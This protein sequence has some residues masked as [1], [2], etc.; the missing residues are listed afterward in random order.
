MRASDLL[1]I[2][3]IFSVCGALATTIFAVLVSHSAAPEF[4]FII[5]T[6]YWI[7]KLTYW[8]GFGLSLTVGMLVGY[9]ASVL[10]GWLTNQ[11]RSAIPRQIIATLM[12]VGSFPVGHIIG[13]ALIEALDPLLDYMLA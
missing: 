12:L 1:K 11:G 9:A 4:W 6:K 8:V 5:G 13:V 10:V 3:L 2:E 7:P